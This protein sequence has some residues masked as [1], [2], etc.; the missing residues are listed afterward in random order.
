VLP[1]LLSLP[2]GSRDLRHLTV[3]RM[4][5]ELCQ[6]LLQDLLLLLSQLLHG[7]RLLHLL[8]LLLLLSPQDHAAAPHQVLQLVCLLLLLLLSL[9]EHWR[10]SACSPH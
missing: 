3:L 5:H 1:L 10:G 9:V 6:A 8:L 7:L 4:Q 2:L